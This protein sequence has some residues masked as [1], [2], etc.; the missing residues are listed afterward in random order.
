MCQG[1]GKRSLSAMP[2]EQYA[3]LVKLI[4]GTFQVPKKD[5][6]NDQNNA[7]RK[8]YRYRERY[9][10]DRATGYLLFGKC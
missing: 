1:G 3:T 6:T 5:R 8:Y 9:T 7:V 10:I 4:K 2:D